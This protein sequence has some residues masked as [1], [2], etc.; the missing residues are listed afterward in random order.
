MMKQ[1]CEMIAVPSLNETNVVHC[2]AEENVNVLYGREISKT[3][4]Y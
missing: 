4:L 3:A 1:E 2:R